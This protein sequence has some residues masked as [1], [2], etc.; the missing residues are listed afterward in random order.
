MVRVV[1]RIL[2]IR[3]GTL[4]DLQITH[5]PIRGREVPA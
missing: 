3:F 4:L 1:H 2:S 5:V